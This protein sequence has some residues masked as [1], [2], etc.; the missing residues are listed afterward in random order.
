MQAFK[1]IVL[2]ADSVLD[3][4]TREV[5]EDG[6]DAKKVQL[7]F[8]LYILLCNIMVFLVFL[9]CYFGSMHS[10]LNIYTG[11]KSGSCRDTGS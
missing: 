1:E 11:H 2:D 6:P 9:F 8:R 4:L 5:T 10:R 7:A 3:T